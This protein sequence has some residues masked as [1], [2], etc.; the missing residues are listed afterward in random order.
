MPSVKNP[1]K[2][3]KNRMAARSSK[4]KKLQRQRVE[5]AQHKISK[6]DAARGARPGLLPSS[7]PN[8]KLSAKKAR[9]LEK[10]MGYAIKRKM[11]AEGIED[12]QGTSSPGYS[13]NLPPR[14]TA[15]V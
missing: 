6:K 13:S 14:A 3:S 2:P 1:N 11:E 15:R 8:R 10:K 12:M 7:G 5:E 4:A 9:K